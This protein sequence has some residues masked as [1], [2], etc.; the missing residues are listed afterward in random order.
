[1]LVDDLRVDV[2]GHHHPLPVNASSEHGNRLLLIVG[3]CFAYE[4]D[5]F[6]IVVIRSVNEDH[7]SFAYEGHELRIAGGCLAYDEQTLRFVD[8]CFEH[9]DYSGR[10]DALHLLHAQILNHTQI[11]NHA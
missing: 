8:E 1:M 6:P 4:N 9:K 10:L 3:D 11:L 7:G 2:V 5:V